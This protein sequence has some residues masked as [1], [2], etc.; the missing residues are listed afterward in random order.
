MTISADLTRLVNNL[1]VLLPG[2]VDAAIQLTLFNVMD[3]FFQTTKAWQE[4]IAFNTTSGQDTYTV[5][6]VEQ[7]EIESLMKVVQKIDSNR[8]NDIPVAATMP[9]L[10]T[11]L[12]GYMPS[13]TIALTATVSLTVIDPVDANNY[14]VYPSWLLPKYYQCILHGVVGTMMAQKAKPYTDE[15][16]AIVNLRSFRNRMASARISVQRE[17]TYT[18]QAWRFPR[19]GR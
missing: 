14:P 2:A 15:R 7:G 17:N 6:P 4:D 12:L 16:L 18:A 5:S 19:F 8:Q 13:S 3:E 11:V 9:S 10:G 1:R